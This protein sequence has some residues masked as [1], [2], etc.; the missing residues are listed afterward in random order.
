[1]H[2]VSTLSSTAPIGAANPSS[3]AHGQ[4]DAVTSPGGSHR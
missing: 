1:M 4:G 2:A 3:Q